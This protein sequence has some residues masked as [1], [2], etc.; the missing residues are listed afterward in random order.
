MI[1][2]FEAM[3]LHPYPDQV[4]IETVCVGHVVRP[5]DKVWLDD[6]VTKDEC[7]T[8][9]KRDTGRFV[10]AINRLVKVKLSQ[11]MVDALC[12]LIFN[13]GE[14]AF[15]T[16]TVLRLLNQGDY[17]GAADAFLLF[18]YAMVLQ[19]DGTHVR[20]PILL[21][22]RES[23]AA[24]FRTGIM[25][26]RFGSPPEPMSVQLVIERAYA[27][28][29]GLFDLNPTELHDHPMA[30]DNDYQTEDGRLVAL[31]PDREEPADDEPVT[32]VEGR[33]VTA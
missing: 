28:Q 9:L 32:S 16:S 20:K 27:L 24:L 3:I 15:A 5:E 14:G 26:V 33:K 13:I 10:R 21:G 30:P 7:L 1:T 25:T 4:G 6:G 23:E 2:G 31:P 17:S 12:S 29:F 19:K 11:P 8:V 18:R 22:R